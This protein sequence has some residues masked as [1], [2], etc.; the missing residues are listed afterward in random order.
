MLRGISALW[1]WGILSSLLRLF[2]LFSD[3]KRGSMSGKNPRQRKTNAVT[4]QYILLY[5]IQRK[6]LPLSQVHVPVLPMYSVDPS[7]P[8]AYPMN[9]VIPLHS[10]WYMYSP[11]TPYEPSTPN[12]AYF[13]ST[14][15]HTVWLEY[16]PTLDMSRVFPCIPYD[17]NTPVH[18]IWAKYSPAY[19]M[20]G[21]LP[22]TPYEPSIPKHNYPIS[23]NSRYP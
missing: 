19:R 1:I 23:P 2:W 4:V 7:S 12:S 17:R 20:I 6:A 3:F 5:N 9:Q 11:C 22:S 16:S 13:T 14:P 15:L 21:I 10:V 8:P 18:S